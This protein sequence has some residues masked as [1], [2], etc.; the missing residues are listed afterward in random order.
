S[1]TRRITHRL[2]TGSSFKV[3]SLMLWAMI[4]A[5]E[6]SRCST[7]GGGGRRTHPAGTLSAEMRFQRTARQHLVE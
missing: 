7:A 4:F 6:W 1:D 5:N 2:N 3:P